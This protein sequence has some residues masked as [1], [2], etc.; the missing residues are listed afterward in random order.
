[1]ITCSLDFLLNLSTSGYIVI[2]PSAV[3]LMVYV[4]LALIAFLHNH[5][6]TLGI[7]LVKRLLRKNTLGGF[8]L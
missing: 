5:L 6:L 8:L 7:Y 2:S 1:M 4:H 3:A